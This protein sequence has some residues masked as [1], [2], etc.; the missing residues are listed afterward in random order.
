LAI[1]VLA[2]V[3]LLAATL[4]QPPPSL[5]GQ[6]RVSDGDSFRLDGIRIRLVGLD[7]PELAQQCLAADGRQWNCGEVARNRMAA[8]LSSGVVRCQPEET[9]QYG[10]LLASCTI[11]GQDPAATMVAEGLAVSSGRY[12]TEEADARRRNAGIWA[13]SFESPRNWRDDRAR[14]QDLF[15]WLT[16]FLP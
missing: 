6:G 1:I 11:G 4:D 10:R 15:G 9:D 13:G 5:A 14:P 8:L 16:T 3:A 2:A 7:A 12:W